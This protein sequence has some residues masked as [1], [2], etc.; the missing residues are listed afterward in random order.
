MGSKTKHNFAC[1]N[2]NDT[3][4]THTRTST[5]TTKTYIHAHAPTNTHTHTHT[6]THISH[7]RKH[8][9]IFNLQYLTEFNVTSLV[10]SKQKL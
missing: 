3:A 10:H 8:N 2:Y 9:Q 1:Y 7:A 6:H 4:H 5:R